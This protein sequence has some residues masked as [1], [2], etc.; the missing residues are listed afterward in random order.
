MNSLNNLIRKTSVEKSPTKFFVHYDEW[1]GN[2]LNISTKLAETNHSMIRTESSIARDIL[3]GKISKKSF[4]V[5]EFSGVKQIVSRNEVLA[6]KK[7]E[8]IL[9]KIPQRGMSFSADINLVLY[10]QDW[11]LEINLNQ[12]TMQSLTGGKHHSANIDKSMINGH[13]NVVLYC[14]EHNRPFN[15]FE[16]IEIDPVDLVNN[17]YMLVDL[18]HLR[19]KV[20]IADLEFLTKRIF[21]NYNLKIKD[22]YVSIDYHSRTSQRRGYTTI[23]SDEKQS[24]NFIISPSTNGWIIK[25]NFDDPL[26]HKIYRDIK[27]FLVDGGPFG[28]V[29]KIV[30]PHNKIGQHREILVSTKVD[31][32]DCF[33][34]MPAENKN[35]TFRY[36]EIKYAKPG[37]Y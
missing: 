23:T 29:D 20:A 6:I 35:I 4:V 16:K 27:I 21:K 25:S 28:L 14:I 34:L 26:E 24:T 3:K 1:T 31:P 8:N 33:M 15:L 13:D 12:D 11:M 9:T 36:E 2:I 32:R 19:N 10:K 17:G 5:A 7:Q 30:L 22:K 37:K 18:N